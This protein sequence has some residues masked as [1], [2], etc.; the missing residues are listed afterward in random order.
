MITGHSIL[1]L[2]LRGRLTIPLRMRSDLHLEFMNTH[3]EKSADLR[4]QF[5]LVRTQ[6]EALSNVSLPV[7]NDCY[8]SLVINFVPP[9][10]TSFLVTDL[11]WTPC[12]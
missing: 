7:S 9:E 12:R 6:Y 5:N 2:L 8:W 3:Y 10:L 4:E 11:V 1:G